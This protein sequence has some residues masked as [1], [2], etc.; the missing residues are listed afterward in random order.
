MVVVS[1]F[2]YQA[3]W[4]TLAGW[5]DRSVDYLPPAAV[6]DLSAAYMLAVQQGAR[7]GQKAA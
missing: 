2:D 1:D 4:H 3:A 5:L 7:Y 6:D